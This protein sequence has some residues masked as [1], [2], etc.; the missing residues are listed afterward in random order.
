MFI[1][2]PNSTLLKEVREFEARYRPKSM[3]TCSRTS[4]V[5]KAVVTLRGWPDPKPLTA[6]YYLP[7]IEA[8]SKGLF[9]NMGTLRRSMA[10]HA[11]VS[12]ML[13][14]IGWSLP[15]FSA[16]NTARIG[17]QFHRPRSRQIGR[18]AD[19]KSCKNPSL[20]FKFNPAKPFLDLLVSVNA[21][22]FLIP[23]KVK[24]PGSE[25]EAALKYGSPGSYQARLLKVAQA[26]A[27]RELIR[28]GHPFRGTWSA[29]MPVAA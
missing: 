17:G 18:N 15:S 4:E 20:Q 2:S 6:P 3:F 12:S 5:Y 29:K 7:E 11:L 28:E 9:P 25:I 10:L 14:G 22:E 24:V 1:V 23:L 26:Y 19:E 16:P 27:E 8:G 21:K 13:A